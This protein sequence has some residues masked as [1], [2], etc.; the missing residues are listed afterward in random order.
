LHQKDI[1]FQNILTLN[2]Y[3]KYIIGHLKKI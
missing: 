2:M 3:K 1:T